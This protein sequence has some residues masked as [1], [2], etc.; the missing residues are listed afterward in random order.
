MFICKDVRPLMTEKRSAPA[1]IPTPSALE[2]A[3]REGNNRVPD[4]WLSVYVY[5]YLYIHIEMYVYVFL[6]VCTYI[7][8]H[9]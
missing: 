5:I 6:Y 4:C 7:H 9:I 8:I 3:A 2:G 1:L